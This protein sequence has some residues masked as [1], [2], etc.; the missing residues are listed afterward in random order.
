MWSEPQHSFDAVISPCPTSSGAADWFWK[1]GMMTLCDIWLEENQEPPHWSVELLPQNNLFRLIFQTYWDAAMAVSRDCGHVAI[2]YS[3]GHTYVPAHVRMLS[4]PFLWEPWMKLV[5]LLARAPVND[6]SG[7]M[8]HSSGNHVHILQCERFPR[9]C[10]M[11]WSL[12]KVRHYIENQRTHYQGSKYNIWKSKYKVQ[13]DS[14]GLCS[15]YV[16]TLLSVSPF[17]LIQD[18]LRELLFHTSIPQMDWEML[19][20]IRGRVILP[21]LG[22]STLLELINA[23]LDSLNLK[24]PFLE[25]QSHAIKHDHAT[26]LRPK[27]PFTGHTAQLGM[28]GTKEHAQHSNRGY[29]PPNTEKS[30]RCKA[31]VARGG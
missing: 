22:S 4:L 29:S 12:E 20:Q 1:T 24:S 10:A 14:T 13:Q 3:N 9:S 18:D 19:Q 28:P 15:C 17:P 8:L 6:C 27:C 5:K 26:Q 21:L 25:T 7:C 2:R 30:R 11:Q 16:H 23:N 31:T